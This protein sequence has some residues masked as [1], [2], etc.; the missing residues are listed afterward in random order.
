[1]PRC[2]ARPPRAAGSYQAAGRAF[3]ARAAR[4]T[5]VAVCVGWPTR[6]A[7]SISVPLDASRGFLVRAV[8]DDEETHLSETTTT[9]EAGCT[10]AKP[11]LTEVRVLRRGFFRGHRVAKLE[12]RPHTG[13]RHQL[14]VHLR[15][16]GHPLVGDATYDDGP[17][18]SAPRMLLHARRLHVEMRF[19]DDDDDDE[20][21][22]STTVTLLPGRPL[23]R[24]SNRRPKRVVVVV[25]AET[26]DPFPFSAAG[27]LVL[28]PRADDATPTPPRWRAAFREEAATTTT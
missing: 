24:R 10:G 28:A 3:E 22:A 14:R 20:A 8:D 11:A 4:K 26:P 9:K 15:H 13:R 1:M 12:L 16:A 18:A 2:H 25:D 19:D 7:L 27:D 5:Y 17:L 21:E 23:R 6:D